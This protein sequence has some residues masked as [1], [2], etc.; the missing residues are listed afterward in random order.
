MQYLQ[1]RCPFCGDFFRPRTTYER[2][3]LVTEHFN[4]C[5]KKQNPCGKIFDI[6][7]PAYRKSPP[8]LVDDF[9]HAFENIITTLFNAGEYHDHYYLPCG[10]QHK[11]HTNSDGDLFNFD[12]KEIMDY[13]DTFIKTIKVLTHNLGSDFEKAE[14][15]NRDILT[16]SKYLKKFFVAYFRNKAFEER[17]LKVQDE[18]M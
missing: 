18:K 5:C 16:T 6:E 11:D 4:K 15:Y 9:R 3:Q 10:H 14:K 12:Q 13:I 17:S 2:N 7:M 8:A 1:F